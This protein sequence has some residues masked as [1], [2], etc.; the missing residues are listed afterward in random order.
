MRLG[1]A[2]RALD[3]FICKTGLYVCLPGLVEGLGELCLGRLPGPEREE[4]RFGWV[5][6]NRN[7]KG[8]KDQA[9]A[10]R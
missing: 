5:L 9:S 2:V 1:T 6:T 10:L 7:R 4:P 3:V 8:I